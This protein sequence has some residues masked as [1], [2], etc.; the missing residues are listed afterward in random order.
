MAA[1]KEKIWELRVPCRLIL[2]KGKSS[3]RFRT[4]LNEL[5]SLSNALISLSE[6]ETKCT[7]HGEVCWVNFWAQF[8]TILDDGAR[9]LRAL[10]DILQRVDQLDNVDHDSASEIR[11]SLRPPIVPLSKTMNI[12]LELYTL[13]VHFSDAAYDL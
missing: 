11:D 10:E 8:G 3:K 7:T 4:L 6:V 2:E 12:A 5:S 1:L 9:I 13:F